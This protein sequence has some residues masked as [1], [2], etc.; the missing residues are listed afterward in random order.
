VRLH[1]A[2]ASLHGAIVSSIASFYDDLVNLQL[3]IVI[4]C[5]VIRRVLPVR[6]MT[7][8]FHKEY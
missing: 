7:P 8:Y 4:L 1:S 6:F 5:D 2:V 3:A